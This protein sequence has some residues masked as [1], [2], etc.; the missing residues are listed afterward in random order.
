MGY[1]AVLPLAF[2]MP[3]G[4]RLSVATGEQVPPGIPVAPLVASGLVRFVPKLEVPE[5]P[6]QRKA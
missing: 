2:P 1:V 5:V 6:K 4:V 3:D